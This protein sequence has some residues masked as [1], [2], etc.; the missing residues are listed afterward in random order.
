MSQR[1]QVYQWST[2]I[3]WMMPGLSRPQAM[4]L[5]AF[6]LGMVLARRCTLHVIAECLWWM[7]KPD[8]V[9]RRL[10]RLVANPGVRVLS[11][12]AALTAWMLRAWPAG[13]P[14]VLLVDETSLQEKLR[15]MVVSLAY[16]HRALPVAWRCYRPSR[17]PAKQVPLIVS[18]LSPVA[19]MLPQG[20][21]V[22]VQA[23]RG[24]G[25]SPTLLRALAKR[26]WCFLVRVQ[27]TVRVR[28]PQGP[29]VPFA[30][31]ATK[32]GCRWEGNVEVFQK[33]GWL[34]CRAIA[35]WGPGQREPWLLVTNAPW[36]SGAHYGL[37]MWEE[38]AFKDFKSAGWQW[39]R[40]HVWEPDHAERL[41]LVMALAYAWTL[42]LGS[43]VLSTP[44]WRQ[45]L[46]R[47]R[48]MRLSQF[49]LGVRVVH[50]CLSLRRP[51]PGHMALLPEPPL[52]IQN[53]V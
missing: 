12:G 27:G 48:S 16:R 23:D 44:T 21:P 50:R 18:L 25:T 26:R 33:A 38:L 40:S 5:A 7:G 4:A 39:H 53:V 41:W 49:Q 29:V 45:E 17:W 10:Q 28:L 8:T 52:L 2:S 47:G 1:K 31:L 20:C 15:V 37:R 43:H 6:S 22:L 36:I 9:E 46:T 51:L 32:G 24:I 11:C 14:V 35:Q 30:R 19:A 34:R 42:A 13:Q 3:V